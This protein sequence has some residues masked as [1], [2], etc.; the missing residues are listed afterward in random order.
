MGMV[1]GWKLVLLLLLVLVNRRNERQRGS[2]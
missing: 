1:V 2:R